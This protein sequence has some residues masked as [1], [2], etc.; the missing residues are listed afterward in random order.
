MKTCKNC[1]QNNEQVEFPKIGALCK[2]CKRE[3]M[4][5]YHRKW[6]ADLKENKP[7][8][9]AK[10]LEQAKVRQKEKYHTDPEFQERAKAYSAKQRVENP[11]GK[12][13]YQQKY[14]A[15]NKDRLLTHNKTKYNN[16]PAA[17]KV[18][19]EATRRWALEHPTERYIIGQ[20]RRA[21][22]AGNGG[23]YTIT[24]IENLKII[25]EDHCIYCSGVMDKRTVEHIVP[26][27]KGGTS[28]AHNVA[29]SCSRCNFSKS[30]NLLDLEWNIYKDRITVENWNIDQYLSG[31]DI[32]YTLIIDKVPVLDFGNTVLT[33]YPIWWTSERHWGIKESSQIMKEINI[34]YSDKRVIHIF[35]DELLNK[36][37]LISSSIKHTLGIGSKIGAREVV[38]KEIDYTTA[39]KF[40]DSHHLQGTVRNISLSLG[41]VKDDNIIGVA[42]FRKYGEGWELARLAFNTTVMGGFSKLLKEFNRIVGPTKLISY[43]DLRWGA[44]KSYEVVGFKDI[45]NTIEPYWYITI[46]GERVNRLQYTLDNMAKKLDYFNPVLTETQ[47]AHI[48]G[49]YRIW[50]LP[51]RTFI[52][53]LK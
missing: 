33:I 17:R 26:L 40:L 7:E 25:Q 11:E 36:K 23:D 39:S 50:G 38:V 1:K 47:N 3:I 8:K 35:S 10:R 6:R 43:C 18:R 12:R 21:K 45:G 15:E 14:Y 32:P 49:L 2:T 51:N 13:E 16:D 5:E 46:E 37:E 29:L 19:L 4:K 44:G 9:H 30:D 27:N 48:N 28:W 34:K 41:L 31:I 22:K 53:D 52:L 20:R 24:H 42:S